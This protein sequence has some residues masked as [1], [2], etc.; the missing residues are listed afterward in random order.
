MNKKIILITLILG[1]TIG[2]A[3][4]KEDNVKRVVIEDDVNINNKED[5]SSKNYENSKTVNSKTIEG[6]T[7]KSIEFPLDEGYYFYPSFYYQGEVYG[8]VWEGSGIKEYVSNRREEAQMEYL[9]KIDK[10]NN[11]IKTSKMYHDYIQVNSQAYPRDTKFIQ[12]VE[13]VVFTV[14]YKSEDIPRPWPELTDVVNKLKGDSDYKLYFIKSVPENENYLVIRETI[15]NNESE[16]YINEKNESI[17]WS[18]WKEKKYIYDI[19]NKKIY[20]MKNEEKDGEIYYVNVLQSLVWV[21]NKD[22]KIYK[23]VFKNGYYSL[24]EYIDLNRYGKA[25]R[26][27]AE[28]KS[29][30]EMILFMDVNINRSYFETKYIDKFNFRTNQYNPLFEVPDEVNI[31]SEYIGHD[32]L[33]IEEFKKE[34]DSNIEIPVKRYFK[35]IRNNEMNTI[36][37]EEIKKES[38]QWYLNNWIVISE[39]GE[40]IFDAIEINKINDVITTEKMIYQKYHIKYSNN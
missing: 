10:D 24:E 13:D 11:L 7:S 4:C 8:C 37:E 33:L 28:M 12:L 14:D 26:I 21:D 39:D 18:D 2:A 23:I 30:D 15:I 34:E 22:F 19:E 16:K 5:S 25:D 32:I 9:Y 1:L 20:R 17:Y 27:R 3:G 40:E 29:D 38:K 35:Q 36:F 31:C 6:I